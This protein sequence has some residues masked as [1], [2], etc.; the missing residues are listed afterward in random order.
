MENVRD[1][2]DRRVWRGRRLEGLRTLL[3]QL[4]QVTTLERVSSADVELLSL[5]KGVVTA[6]GTLTFFRHNPFMGELPSVALPLEDE[7]N[8]ERLEVLVK[9]LKH[10]RLMLKHGDNK[11]FTADSLIPTMTARIGAGGINAKRPSY[12]RDAYFAE[13]LGVTEQDV[14]LLVRT[15]DGV[16]KVFAMHS[17]RYTIVPQTTILDIIGQ[18]ESGLGKPVCRQW[19]VS[20]AKTEVYLEFPEKAADFAKTYNLPKK[21]VPGL[22]LITS[23]VGDSSVCAIGTWRLGNAP[24]GYEVYTRKH[25]GRVDTEKILDQIGQRIFAKYDRI[26]KRLCELMKVEVPEP[27]DCVDSIFEQ[28]GLKDKIGVRRMAQVR[29]IVRDQFNYVVKYTAYD[30]AIAIMAL[31]DMVV[32]MTKGVQQVFADCISGAVFADYEEYKTQLVAIPA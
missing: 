4:D 9:E 3:E 2:A 18:I 10:N 12:K 17:D 22:R 6:P 24:L 28:I 23:D 27:M 19:E 16:R 26:P 21:I 31:P 14:Q 20:N 13:L 15:F 25:T 1:L 29:E 7:K 32:G 30:V 8:R 11:Y 5:K